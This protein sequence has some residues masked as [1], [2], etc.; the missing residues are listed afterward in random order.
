MA[1]PLG[2][3][4]ATTTRAVAWAASFYSD[5]PA[6]QRTGVVPHGIAGTFTAEHS[7][8]AKMIGAFGAHKQ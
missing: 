4:V 7:G 8:I 5:L 1:P 6:N 2:P 3:S